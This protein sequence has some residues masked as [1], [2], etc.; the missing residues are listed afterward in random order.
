[1][2]LLY[3][4][5]EGAS[6]KFTRISGPSLSQPAAFG[7]AATLPGGLLP[8]AHAGLQSESSHKAVR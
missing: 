8:S 2:H 5:R 4:T 6:L 7:C 1:M 3:H